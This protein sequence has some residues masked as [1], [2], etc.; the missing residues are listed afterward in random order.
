M[1]AAKPALGIDVPDRAALAAIVV[2]ITAFAVAQGLT[3]P[4]ISLI[5]NER[6]LGGGLI[7]AN[8][9]M[10]A[11][12]IAASTLLTPR[13]TRAVAPDRL[14]LAGLAGASL[15]LF[16]FALFE[17][18]WPWFAIRF[19]LGFCANTI[20]VLGEAW[21]NAACP[22]RLRGRVSGLYAAGMCGGFALGPVGVPLFGKEGGFAFAAAAVY[23]ALV[24]FAFGTLSRRSR[25]RPETAAPGSLAA[26][27]RA[28]PLLVLLVAM[29]GFS[30]VA[31]IAVLPVYLTEA[32][33]SDDLAALAVTV[34]HLPTI[35]AQPAIGVLLDR[36]PRLL[37]ALA[38]L[39]LTALAYALI[40]WCLGTRSLWA[41]LA[42]LGSTSFGLYTA[43]LALLG[44]RFTGSL[45]V[46]GSA[47]FG[48]TY[49]VGS[50]V[51]ST[52]TGAAM[53]VLGPG[54]A[55]LTAASVLLAAALLLGARLA[56]PG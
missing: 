3:Y 27:V 17:R 19:A 1:T 53:E 49:A 33:Y 55:P 36:C 50:M 30:D 12:G 47:V 22:D 2:G 51:G 13:M 26:F 37:V 45:L 5:L 52:A 56:R 28:A 31:A 35:A 41:V 38:C 21:L 43:A 11:L 23:V 25:T 44:Q 48:V 40:P 6:G 24:A 34:M 9:A 7:G 18:V 4:L 15:C 10:F 32:G 46:A 54:G 20:F 39:L 42:L 16:A 8:A 14:I 29:F